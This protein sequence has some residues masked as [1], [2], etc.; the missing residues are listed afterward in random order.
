VGITGLTTDD[1]YRTPEHRRHH[2]RDFAPNGIKAVV[3]R[4]WHHRDDGPGGT[5]VFLTNAAVAKPRQPVD[6]YDDRSLIEHGCI[7]ERQQPW[8]LKQPPRTKRGRCR[9]ASCSP[10]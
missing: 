4:Q 2:R 10:C 3:V 7:K 9:G 6:V 1:Q 5:T 8:S